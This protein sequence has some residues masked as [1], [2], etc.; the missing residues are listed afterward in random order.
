MKLCTFEVATHLGRH[1]RL[2]AYKDG[3][4]I[5]L[6]FAAAW[7]LSQQGE[8]EPQPLA[9]AMVPHHLLDFLRAGLRATHTAEELFQT[10]PALAAE[11]WKG[12]PPPRGPNDETLVYQPEQVKLRAPLPH[13]ARLGPDE[14]VRY[15]EKLDH[16]FKL[17]AV[18]GSQ[19]THVNALGARQYIAGF[20]GMHDFGGRYTALGPCLVTPD[21]IGNPYNLEIA[22]RING[23]ECGRTNSGVLRTRFEQMIETLTENGAVLPGD[24]IGF[25]LDLDPPMTQGDLVELEIEKIGILRTRVV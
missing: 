20:T 19:G 12:D 15:G 6:N 13:P 25:R 1:S 9:D 18:I 2:G 16:E 24:I 11:W 4:I 8:S 7:Y 3:R 17:A 23:K 10:N 14:D 21:E 22:V 5:D